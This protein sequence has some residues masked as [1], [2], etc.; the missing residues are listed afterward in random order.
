MP[1]GVL[2]PAPD[3]T[4]TLLYC[5]LP[6]PHT[7]FS[8]V[9]FPPAPDLRLPRDFK[10]AVELNARENAVRFV[11]EGKH[12]VVCEA[13]FKLTFIGEFM[14][15]DLRLS[16]D[17]LR[18]SKIS[19]VDIVELECEITEEFKLDSDVLYL[20]HCVLLGLYPEVVS[21]LGVRDITFHELP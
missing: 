11:G 5:S 9:N 14:I 15:L 1:L 6:S 18:L 7:M 21:L 10:P 19:V 4:I 13:F 12:W 16:W 17:S 20:E 2:I 3:M 8:A